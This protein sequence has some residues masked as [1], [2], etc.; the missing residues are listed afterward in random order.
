VST[1]PYDR[2]CVAVLWRRDLL[3]FVKQRSRVVGAITTTLLMWLV[4]GAGIAPSFSPP[5]ADIGYMEYF[6]PGVI[7]MLML[8]VSISAT[9]SVI[10]DRSQGFLQGVLVAPGSRAALVIGKT[11]GSAT[12]ALLHAVLFLA[13]APLA[14]FPFTGISWPLLFAVLALAG[15]ALTGVGFMLAWVLDS[16]QGY[17][18]VMNLVLFPL[19]ILSGA[20]FPASGLHP[21]LGTIVR[22][23][24]MSY[25]MSG[26][27]RALYGG[28]M[29]AGVGPAGIAVSL[30]LLVLLVTTI[31]LLA[32]ACWVARRK[33]T[34][35]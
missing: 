30:E 34:N 23:N 10:E 21:V 16:V 33:P 24:P 26:L 14:G 17:H 25:A 31:T 3:L 6:Y 29:P 18:V 13:L 27:R 20:M 9:M 22:F 4:I 35:L 11:A 32:A 1:L 2:S 19:W 15:L 8:Q 7:L 12:V 5:A 28:D